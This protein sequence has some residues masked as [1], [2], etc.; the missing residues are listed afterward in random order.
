M[1]AKRILLLYIS[2]DSGHHRASRA[3]E[4]AFK[5][6]DPA[7]ETMNVN[8]FNYTNPILEKVINK[9]Y[10]S[11]IRS[12]PEFWGY[13]YDNPKIVQKTQRLR[14]VIHRHNTGKLKTLIDD[15]KPDAVICTQAFP[16]GMVADYKRTFNVPLGLYGVL[17]DYAPHSYWIFN[18]VDA[19]FV[20]SPE[21]GQKIVQ[22]GIPPEK[23]IASGIPIDPHF[24][25]Q[26][27]RDAVMKKLSLRKDK[28]V[29]LIM[30]GSQGVCPFKEVLASLVRSRLDVQVIS[31]S[32]KNKGAYRWFVRHEK[33]AAQQGLKLL[34]FGFVDNTNELMDIATVL[35][36]KPGGITTAEA[37]AKG[38]PLLI[39]NP[40]PG[41]EEMNTQ[42]LLK[43]NVAIRIDDPDSVGIVVEELL[44]NRAKLAELGSSAVRF[45]KPDSA[46]TIARFVLADMRRKGIQS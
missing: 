14:D 19:Y 2:N 12:R 15:F 30:G 8:S 44:Y 3:V 20:P 5:L 7:I 26:C 4:K 41:Q 16:C 23:V 25:V 35:I 42:H 9:T 27:D 45:S 46:M 43:N 32:G 34:S 39:V 31:V 11:V 17:T 13:L 37:L 38:V 29:I 10:M 33:W 1:N 6:L 36:S 22:N 40:I 18:T 28:P 21:T 24:T